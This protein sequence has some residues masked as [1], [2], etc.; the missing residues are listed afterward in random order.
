MH[1]TDKRIWEAIENGHFIPLKLK[2]DDVFVDKPPSEWT[3]G[4]SKKAKFGWIAKNII[5][6]ALSCDE[7]FSKRNVGHP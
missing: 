4:D 2:K 6:S 3:E 5:T 7:F 1:S